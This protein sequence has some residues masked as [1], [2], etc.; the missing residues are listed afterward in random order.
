MANAAIF[1]YTYSDGFFLLPLEWGK[2]D[3]SLYPVTPTVKSSNVENRREQHIQL[4]EN[5]KCKQRHCE[6]GSDWSESFV[7]GQW[8][9]RSQLV[10]ILAIFQREEED[11][12]IWLLDNLKA[13]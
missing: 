9:I 8:K 12:L 6:T 4:I 1:H 13:H 7:K 5:K 3:T 11:C 10:W 2:C